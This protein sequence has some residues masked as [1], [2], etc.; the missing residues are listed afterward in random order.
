MRTSLLFLTFTTLVV[1]YVLQFQA[2]AAPAGP[3]IKHLSSLLK[4]SRSSSKTPQSD[5]NFLQFESGYLVETVV[6]EMAWGRLVAGS[7]QGYTGHVDGKPS[8]AR[9]NHPKV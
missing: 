7:F 5:G 4:W 1:A 3:L 2:H 6:E 9:F 8:D